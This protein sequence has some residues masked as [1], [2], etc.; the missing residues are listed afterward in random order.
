MV[1]KTLFGKL[2]RVAFMYENS[3]LFH[4]LKELAQ[5]DSYGK[6]IFSLFTQRKSL[7]TGSVKKLR[8]SKAIFC[9]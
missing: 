3:G 2:Y 1:H 4:K 6:A 5:T 9:V 8:R 7:Y